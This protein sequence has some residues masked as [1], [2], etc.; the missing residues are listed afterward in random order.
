QI[1]SIISTFNDMGI[2]VYDE[3]PDAET[4]LIA[5]NTPQAVA[6]EDAEGS[7]HSFAPLKFKPNR[8]AVS[9]NAGEGRKYSGVGHVLF[10]HFRGSGH[11]RRDV[12]C[13]THRHK[14]FCGVEQESCRTPFRSQHAPH[15]RR[16][17]V[18]APVFPDVNSPQACKQ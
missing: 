14:A 1:E 6:D 15:V 9:H 2:Q 3:A 10:A 17:D 16:P 12:L 7:R 13:Q 11:L 5:E 8:K 4:L 18:S